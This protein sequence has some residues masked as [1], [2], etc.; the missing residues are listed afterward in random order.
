VLAA[1]DPGLLRRVQW[2]AQ[3]H[4]P[5]HTVERA[6]SRG[7]G[8]HSAAHGLAAGDEREVGG[9][10][11]GLRDR[12]PDGGFQYCGRVWATGAVLDVRKLVAER[13]HAATSEETGHVFHET[14]PHAGAGAVGE[15]EDGP[16][17]VGPKEEPGHV[18]DAVADVDVEP[19][20][21]SSSISLPSA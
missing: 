3:E 6:P 18:A 15:D 17:V 11:A 13:G 4:E 9:K 1:G 14:V 2:K 8:G 12:G 10:L 16:G 19:C 5:A 7:V 20:H 21:R